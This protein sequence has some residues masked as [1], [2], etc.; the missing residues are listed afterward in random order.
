M[1]LENNKVEAY[2]GELM[3]WF[4]NFK[5]QY[6]S[7]SYPKNLEGSYAELYGGEIEKFYKT[8]LEIPP[9][10]PFTFSITYSGKVSGSNTVNPNILKA[11]N[12][13]S[14]PANN[15]TTAYTEFSSTG[16]GKCNILDND[17]AISTTTNTNE[18]CQ[19]H[20]SFN[21]VEELTRRVPNIFTGL[22][23]LPQKVAKAKTAINKITCNWH[24][25]ARLNTVYTANLKTYTDS[26][27]SVGT[28]TSSTIARI[29]NV[30]ITDNGIL[31][32][33][34][35]YYLAHNNTDGTT[36]VKELRTDYIE[37]IIEGSA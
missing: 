11:G 34:F 35:I 7:Y 24:G 15:I 30:D 10:T 12:F 37:L 21:I 23:T 32:D 28:H 8:T 25:L 26:W 33:G 17:P 19:H 4:K 14:L 36:N 27:Y 1:P 13:T 16:Y 29:Q 6:P 5:T 31:A 2:N 18:M 22:T 20:F 3:K 9:T